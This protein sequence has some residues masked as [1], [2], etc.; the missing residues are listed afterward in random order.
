MAVP[1]GAADGFD[2]VRYLER[3]IRSCPMGPLELDR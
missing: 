2:D 1:A 3:L